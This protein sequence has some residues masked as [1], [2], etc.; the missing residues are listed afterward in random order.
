[1][2]PCHAPGSATPSSQMSDLPV[3][4]Q[5]F[6]FLT[7]VYI[8]KCTTETVEEFVYLFRAPKVV[9]PNKLRCSTPPLSRRANQSREPPSLTPDL[10]GQAEPLCWREAAAEAGTGHRALGGCPNAS[11]PSPR[12]CPVPPRASELMTNAIFWPAKRRKNLNSLFQESGGVCTVHWHQLEKISLL[13]RLNGNRNIT[14]SIYWNCPRK[15]RVAHTF[16]SHAWG[17]TRIC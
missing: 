11:A 15:E 5:A 1:M 17:E 16:G 12:N 8:Y 3:G 4:T 6:R 13:I 10:E 9:Q 14:S 2:S 7:H